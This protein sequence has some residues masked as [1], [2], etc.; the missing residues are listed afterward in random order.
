MKKTIRIFIILF[1][2]FLVINGCNNEKK[3]ELEGFWAIYE[4]EEGRIGNI[5]YFGK[6]IVCLDLGRTRGRAEYYK[7]PGIEDCKCK[8]NPVANWEMTNAET[9]TITGGKETRNFKIRNVSNDEFILWEDVG[10]FKFF[11]ISKYQ[12]I[13]HLSR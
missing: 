9:I 13:Y 3:L 1:I 2:S 6:D 5:A 7:I 11:R 12:A 8:G 10:T 4:S